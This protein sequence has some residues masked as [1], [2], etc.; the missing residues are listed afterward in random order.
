MYSFL[1]MAIKVL[2]IQNSLT[3]FSIIK[4]K[5]KWKMEDKIVVEKGIMKHEMTQLNEELKENFLTWLV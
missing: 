3:E 4:Y 2:F 5:Q 1:K